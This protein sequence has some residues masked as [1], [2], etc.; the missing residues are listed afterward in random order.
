MNPFTAIY[1][2][3]LDLRNRLDYSLRQRVHASS[4]PVHLPS[5]TRLDI[6]SAYPAGIRKLAGDEIKRLRA[7]YHFDA[8]EAGFTE[9]G[10]RENYFYLAMLDEAFRRSEA[11]LPAGVTAADIGPSSWFYVQALAASLTHYGTDQPRA[12]HLTGFE[13][14]AYRLYADFHTRRDHAL[15][16]MRGLA[17]V[18]YVDQGFNPA[19]SAYDVITSF[20]PFVFEKDHMEWGLPGRLF[21]PLDLLNASLVSLKPGGLLVIVNQGLKEHEE[22]LRFLTEAGGSP[23]AAFKMEPLLFTYPL[24][25]YIITVKK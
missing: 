21:H 9:R 5:E 24:D 20:F 8:V 19:P 22:E 4:K 6:L 11:A 23:T 14:D 3:F 1:F 16:N 7:A 2:T 18:E 17:G 12:I 13:V 10:L 15:S 25:R